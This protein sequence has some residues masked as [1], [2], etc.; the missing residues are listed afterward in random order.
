MTDLLER[1]RRSVTRGHEP[2]DEDAIEAADEIE[3]LRAQLHYANG[4]CDLAMKHRDVAEAE[5]ER[6]RSLCESLADDCER[7]LR[8]TALNHG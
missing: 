7:A 4:T 1:L 2:T 6:L 5:V 8:R 3:R